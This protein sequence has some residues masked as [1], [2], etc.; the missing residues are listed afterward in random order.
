MPMRFLEMYSF[1]LLF[2]LDKS[3]GFLISRFSK[4]VGAQERDV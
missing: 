2:Q 4:T 3:L 1:T